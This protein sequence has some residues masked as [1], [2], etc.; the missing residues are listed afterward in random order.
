MPLWSFGWAS[1]PGSGIF[2]LALLLRA[3][4]CTHA[5]EPRR[6]APQPL[7]AS[8]SV[9]YVGA[10][11]QRR[12]RCGRV[13]DRPHS[14][15]R[16]PL[17]R[18]RS[19][20]ASTARPCR[21]QRPSDAPFARALFAC[22]H[23]VTAPVAWAEASGELGQAARAGGSKTPRCHAGGWGRDPSSGVSPRARQ[24]RASDRGGRSHTGI[25]PWRTLYQRA[26]G[27]PDALRRAG[28]L[29]ARTMVLDVEP[30]VEV[31]ICL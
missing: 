30:L 26:T 14:R 21:D 6:V 18:G 17:M 19:R 23:H 29:R 20:S 5:P 31:K 15:S 11:H 12:G 9:R 24:A 7:E 27:L 10:V 25:A 3:W 2:R 8:P 22:G 13:A 16:P 4:S 1:P 28:E